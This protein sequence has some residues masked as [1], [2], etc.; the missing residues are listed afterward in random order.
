V[1]S[2]LRVRPPIRENLAKTPSKVEPR[3]LVRVALLFTFS[4]DRITSIEA[5]AEPERLATLDLV[6]AD[7]A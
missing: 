5:I 6:V 3:G 1:A 7:D 4:A 2:G